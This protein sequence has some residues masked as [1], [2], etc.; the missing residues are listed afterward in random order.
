MTRTFKPGERVAVGRG[1]PRGTV[2]TSD[3]LIMNDWPSG[4]YKWNEIETVLRLDDG[5]EMYHTTQYNLPE[6]FPTSRQKAFPPLILLRKKRLAR[7]FS[8]VEAR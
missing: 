4:R 2:V 8:V 3:S 6:D 7:G 1:G 5:N